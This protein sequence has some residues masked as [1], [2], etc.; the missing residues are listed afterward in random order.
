MKESLGTYEAR[1]FA[2]TQFR[3]LR[4]VRSGE[5][6][7][8]LGLTAEQER[9]LFRRL[10]RGGLIVRIRPGLYLVPKRLP[11]GGAW[12]PD[13]V[14]ALNTLF[15]DRG[16]RYQICGPNAFNRYGFDEQLPTRTYA[17]NNRISGTRR[18]GA[19]Q[20]SL[21]K[22]SDRRLG[23]T[24]E[25]K[26]RDG[27]VGVYASRARTLLDAVYDWSRLDGLP[28]G[29]RWIRDDL[30]S[31]QTLPEEFVGIV[32]RYGDVGTRRRIGALLELAGIKS[33][34]LRRIEESLANTTSYIPWIPT[35]PKRGRTNARWRVV[36]NGS[37]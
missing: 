36:M 26:T 14:L 7:Q 31:G 29:Y 4:T 25:V 5:L 22:V 24:V 27:E 3:G 8:Q 23:G 33:S 28:R 18:I 32:L 13:E 11:V 9:E 1:F 2:Y 16:G 34:L 10:S 17:Y 35:L 12:S 6:K 37:I 15:E 21:I 19:V 20:L 30:A